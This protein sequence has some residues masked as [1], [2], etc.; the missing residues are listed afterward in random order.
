[1]SSSGWRTHLTHALWMLEAKE[2]VS[3]CPL[4]FLAGFPTGGSAPESGTVVSISTVGTKCAYRPK[5]HVDTGSLA[6]V[7]DPLYRHTLTSNGQQDSGPVVG[8]LGIPRFDLITHSNRL[9]FL[10][11][12]LRGLALTQVSRGQKIPSVT[13][14]TFTRPFS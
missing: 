7:V 8:G 6:G 4:L 2:P 9:V 11:Q 13:H 10:T 12:A 1:M 5:W 3:T 14:T